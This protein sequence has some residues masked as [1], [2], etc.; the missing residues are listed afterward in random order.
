MVIKFFSIGF[1]GIAGAI[2]SLDVVRK[3]EVSGALAARF[4]AL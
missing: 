4:T 2:S 3:S 1:C